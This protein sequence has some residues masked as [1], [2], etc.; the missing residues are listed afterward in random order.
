MEY[1]GP[2]EELAELPSGEVP[3]IED[4]IHGSHSSRSRQGV[5]L[6]HSNEA[7][8]SSEPLH[9]SHVQN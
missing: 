1:I 8:Y 5:L 7:I 6:C 2:S 4:G 3:V 9:C